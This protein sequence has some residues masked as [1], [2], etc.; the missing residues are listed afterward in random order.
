METV[1]SLVIV[2]L[3]AAA[4]GFI[5][6]AADRHHDVYGIMLPVGAAV[7]VGCVVWIILV[8]AGAGYLTGMTWM[9]WILPM[10][11]GVAAAAAV[12][13]LVGRVRIKHDLAALTEILKRG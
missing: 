3:V 4:A 8:L 2:I 1:W 6:W 7:A 12:P 5:A 11:L 10:A 13:T 9:P